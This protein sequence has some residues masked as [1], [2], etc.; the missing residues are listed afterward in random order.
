M[1]IIYRRRFREKTSLTVQ[2]TNLTLDN[3]YCLKINM[4][5]LHLPFIQKMFMVTI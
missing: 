1:H 3:L 5:C 2:K 4:F